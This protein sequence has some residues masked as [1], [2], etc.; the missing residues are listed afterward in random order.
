MR[1]VVRPEKFPAIATEPMHR[2]SVH[3]PLNG[4]P[5]ADPIL[6]RFVTLRRVRWARWRHVSEQ[7]FELERCGR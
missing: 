4:E 7:N 6:S 5:R 3:A 1:I 2:K